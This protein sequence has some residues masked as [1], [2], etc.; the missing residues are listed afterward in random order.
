MGRRRQ[1]SWDGHR[2]LLWVSVKLKL[3]GVFVWDRSKHFSTCDVFVNAYI[4]LK[5]NLIIFALMYFR[6][7]RSGSRYLC[8]CVLVRSVSWE[9]VVLG[10]ANPKLSG[11]YSRRS[12]NETFLYKRSSYGS[13]HSDQQFRN[14]LATRCEGGREQSWRW[15]WKI[16]LF[17][18]V[19][20]DSV[21]W[22]VVLLF[23]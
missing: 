20:C 1:L 10:I 4:R 22:P 11:N 8:F 7:L 14:L 6:F 3:C 2:Q 23:W 12:R 21:V 17:S 9:G 15:V 5:L 13:W 16:F 18:C 19:R